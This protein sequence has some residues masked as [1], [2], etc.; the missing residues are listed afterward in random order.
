MKNVIRQS[1]YMEFL[2]EAQEKIFTEVKDRARKE[3]A[4]TLEAWMTVVDDIIEGHEEFGEINE[5]GEQELREVLRDR[6][7]EFK[8]EAS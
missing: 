1:T 6:F 2:E 4:Y 5:E 3:G 7:E 8:S